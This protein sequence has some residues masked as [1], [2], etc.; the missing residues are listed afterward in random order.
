MTGSSPNIITMNSDNQTQMMLMQ[1]VMQNM[2]PEQQQ[3][4]QAALQA[5]AKRLANIKYMQNCIRKVAASLTNG[6]ASQAYTLGSPLT[7]NLPTSISGYA[8]GIILRYIVNYTLAAGTGATY[9]ATAGGKLALI[10]TVEV[11]YNKSQMKVRPQVLRQL[12]LLGGLEQFMLPDGVLSGQQDAYLQS[13]LNSTLGVAVGAN[14]CQVEVYIPFNL[15]NSEDPRGILPLMSGDTGIQVIVNTPQSILGSDAVANAIYESGGT[16]GA[17][18]AIS[19]TVAVEVVYRDG[20]TYT[21][22]DK[23]PF[24]INSV[25]GTFQ[26]QIDQTLTPLVANT[27]QRTKLN[28]MGYHYYVILLVVDALQSNSYSTQ[29]NITY[30]ESSKDGV[31][32]NAFER[33]GNQTNL[34]YREYLFLNRLGGRQDLDAGAIPMIAAP[35]HGR[36]NYRNRNGSN[37]LDN[38]RSGWAD[39]R[40]GVEVAS[41]GALGNGPRIEPHVFY[42]NP[43]GLV[44]V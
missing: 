32:G 3:Q 41:V 17:I 15:L 39:W 21:Q 24:D 34:D 42:I 29:A 19:G 9:A 36:N 11:R 4:L 12:A 31:G 8:E 43:T 16:G 44:P 1:A 22:T 40:Y 25:N 18:S 37:Y 28:I 35:V 2:K 13:W 23:L 33:F 7:F 20:D 14:T 27:V 6:A 10:D 26:A 30:V 5:Q 38:T